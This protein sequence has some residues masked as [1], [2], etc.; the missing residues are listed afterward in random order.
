MAENRF[1]SEFIVEQGG[2]DAIKEVMSHHSGNTAVMK[3]VS[4]TLKN[5]VLE[6]CMNTLTSHQN[7]CGVF[8]LD[9]WIVY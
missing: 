8:A 3:E 9:K 4:R 1:N 6:Q 7:E 2:I 5:G